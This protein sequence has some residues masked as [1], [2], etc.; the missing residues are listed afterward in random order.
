MEVGT[1]ALTRDR[2]LYNYWRLRMQERGNFVMHNEGDMHALLIKHAREI[3]DGVTSFA[4]DKWKDYSG[5]GSR[6]IPQAIQDD[7]TEIVDGRFFGTD[8]DRYMPKETAL[9]FA[10]GLLLAR[11]VREEAETKIDAVI[12]NAIDPIQGVDRTADILASA[13]A[14]SLM[15]NASPWVSLALFRRWIGLQNVTDAAFQDVSAY[16]PTAPEVYF[17]LLEVLYAEPGHPRREWIAEALRQHRDDPNVRDGLIWRLK[18]WMGCWSLDDGMLVGFR[19]DSDHGRQMREQNERHRESV[20]RA[21]SQLTT[22]E[23]S[24]FDQLCAKVQNPH[25]PEIAA[26]VEHIA[27]GWTLAPLAEGVLAW[28]LAVEIG[29]RSISHSSVDWLFKMN[30]T[31]FGAAHGA[32]LAEGARALAVAQ[33]RQVRNAA[34]RVHGFAGM[35][36]DEAR[37]N[38]LFRYP[39]EI[40]SIRGGWHWLQF[41]CDTDPLDPESPPPTSLARAQDVI[42]GTPGD[43]VNCSFMTTMED[44]N[45]DGL[46]GALA[47]FNPAPFSPYGDACSTRCLLATLLPSDR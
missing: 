18:R 40:E 1:A 39:P 31:D 22:D 29:H 25:L 21:L 12:D 26:S 5:A 24:L 3:R 8:G 15:D 32:L 33:C 2:L 28:C 44:R 27:A 30:F 4:V 46:T 16:V 10:L 36:E 45:V 34:A 23:R 13:T 37:L 41:F 7:L 9:P 19:G 43:K 14:L 6:L 35:P 47:R 20:E 17:D 38:E 42:D 11:E